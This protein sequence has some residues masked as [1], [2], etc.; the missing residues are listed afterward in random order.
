[1]PTAE[2]KIAVTPGSAKSRQ[3]HIELYSL[4]ERRAAE[5]QREGKPAEPWTD[6]ARDFFGEAREELADAVNYLTW[7]AMQKQIEA[8]G[9]TPQG[10]LFAITFA[11]ASLIDAWSAIRDAEELMKSARENKEAVNAEK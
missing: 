2:P 10:F 8:G 6:R 4:A 5:G 9:R 1:M 7:A 3:A 11:R